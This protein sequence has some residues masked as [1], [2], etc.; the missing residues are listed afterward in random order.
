MSET[1]LVDQAAR[2]RIRDDLDRTLFVEA[3]AGTGKTRSMVERVVRLLATG[4]ATAS[5][6]VAI[7]FTEAAA[8]ELR[9]R[10]RDALERLVAMPD[11][12][13]AERERCEAAL[14]DL[15]GAALETIHAFCRRL[16]A[17]HP[18]EAGL[19]PAFDVMD[20]TEGEA[21]FAE[22]W[23]GWFEGTLTRADQEEQTAI[24]LLRAF[25]LG[26]TPDGLRTMASMLRQDWD[27]L[28][29][30]TGRRAQP[31]LDLAPH[32][33]ALDEVGA[34]IDGCRVDSDRLAQHL[35]RLSGMANS[36][37]LARDEMAALRALE[38]VAMRGDGKPWGAF[39]SMG[40]KNNW[41]DI[42]AVRAAVAAVHA[43]AFEAFQAV[44][45]AAT[46]AVRDDLATF[47]LEAAEERRRAGRV[48]F[49][50]LLV[51]TRHMLV[52]RADVREALRARYSH[53]FIDEFQDTD[54]LQ[55]EIAFLL[56][57]APSG[58]GAAVEDWTGLPVDEGRL[59]FVGDP[60][61]SI[62]RFRRADIDLYRRVRERFEDS[63]VRLTQNFRSV[64]SVIAWVNAQFA[65]RF[66][67]AA[68]EHQ[69]PHEDLMAA[70]AALPLPTPSS[71]YAIG[72]GRAGTAAEIRR[73]E[74]GDIVGLLRDIRRGNWR[75]RDGDGTRVAQLR[76]VAIL[77]RARSN[78]REIVEAL[79]DAAIPH[80]I[81]SRS[82]V[83]EA[84]EIRDLILILRAIDD[85]TDEV[86]LLGTLRSP[87]FAC[88]DDDLVRYRLAG[89]RWDFRR[90][91]PEEVQGGPVAEALRWV[92][93][94]HER[95]WWTPLPAL[96]DEVLLGRRLFELGVVD[97]RPRERWQRLRFVAEQ[98]RAHAE[99][100][101]ATLRSL[102][103]WL[104]WQADEGAQV[105]ERV[106]PEPDDDAVR[107]M[108][109]HASKGLQFPLV[110]LVGLG[111]KP[112]VHSNAV[113]WS[114]H[115]V[116]EAR[117]T[118]TLQTAGY[119]AQRDVDT[120]LDA[121]E[122]ARLLY[123]AMTRAEDH[124]VLSLFHQQ[125]AARSQATPTVAEEI[126]AFV[127]D[128]PELCATLEFG[129]MEAETP[130]AA[131]PVEPGESA[132]ARRRWVEER[133]ALLASQAR[134]HVLSA[135]V[136]AKELAERSR[137][138]SPEVDAGLE[139]DAP[140]D[141]RPPWRRGRAGT[142]IGRAVHSVLQTVDLGAPGTLRDIAAAQA[143]AEGVADRVDEV[144]RLARAAVESEPVRQAI[145]G[146]RYWREVYVAA[147]FDG[148]VVDGFIDL[149]YETEE[150]YVVADYKT[151]AIGDREP[152]AL[153][154][155]YRPQALAYAL[156]LSGQLTRPVARCEFIFVGAPGGAV[157]ETVEVSREALDA[158][159]ASVAAVAG[160]VR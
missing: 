65:A 121:L 148:V 70:R 63:V 11:A 33:Q 15:D 90:D 145:A 75:V 115:G 2:D 93:E 100:P 9:D 16:L 117:L 150:G 134:R 44:S 46:R 28:T 110:V 30:P 157:V 140:T 77:A 126:E 154:E 72:G 96:I 68:S 4:R 128:H 19:P 42:A 158:I 113:L 89:G 85:P 59:F 141:D 131:A 159:Q 64:P 13:A 151:D 144:E 71:V 92:R 142:A 123:V 99:R 137:P 12:D 80:R 10:V 135:T 60:K 112:R 66:D 86:A 83:F 24:P 38:T 155:R 97:R 37:R 61:Q 129:E 73:E 25:A 14:A 32:A 101:E 109:I 39:S 152:A 88:G 78:L 34:L 81:E 103:D 69:A 127:A 26:A 106:V 41:D 29:T 160:G 116:P 130:A 94:L 147:E 132:D 57:S 136:L 76:D 48:E 54:P 17:A 102:I 122:A 105:Q 84:Q 118:K 55:A 108:T 53:V 21:L 119:E 56:G 114:G 51:M 22:Q 45:D 36:L 98:A 5:S 138:A 47:V 124:L 82:M 6:I 149:L 87:A 146:G 27:R 23:D 133:Q 18:L 52:G 143:T 58:D 49:Q 153:A 120:E 31:A 1:I 67:A 20:A 91:A 40:N 104:Q 7:T 95:R 111:S 50:D 107:I 79:E 156:V 74:A 35:G 3:G 125:R 62:Y 43:G 8:A 139:K